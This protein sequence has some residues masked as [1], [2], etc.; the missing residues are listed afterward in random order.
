[1][2]PTLQAAEP[3]HARVLGVG[4]YRPRRVVTNPE[5]CAHIDS[6]PEWI[7]SRSGIRTRRFAGPDETLC[8]M[9]VSAGKAALADAGIDPDQLDCV[10]VASMSNL[11][12]TPP[13]SV[14]VADELGAR[15][16]AGFDLSAACAGFCHALAVAGDLVRAGSARQVLVIGAERMT[17]IVD[18]TDRTIAF[19]FADGAGAAVVGSS[20]EPGIGP[21]VRWADGRSRGGLYMNTTWAQFRD[22]PTLEWPAMKMDGQRVFR[23]VVENAVPAA[24]EALRRA[25]IGVGDLAAFI[26][27]QANVRMIEVLADRLGLPAAVAVSRDV[28]TAGNT[29]AASIPL[30]MRAMLDAGAAEPGGAALLI[31]FGAGLNYAGQVALLPGR[32]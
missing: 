12:Q 19:M 13:L 17:D 9:A 24:K 22:D 25:G 23:W 8:A 18:R 29:S 6:T 4:A 7:E 10:I 20:A 27:H 11:V 32:S 31:G 5:V 16:S 2:T 28:V 1:M 21:V 3:S 30:A 15:N 14:L 26:P